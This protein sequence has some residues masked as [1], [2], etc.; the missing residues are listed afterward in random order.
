[1]LWE[2]EPEECPLNCRLFSEVRNVLMLWERG[3][4]EQCPWERDPE[5]FTF[6]GR[7]SLS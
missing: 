7:L 1:M 6:V 5:K 3:Y 2:R 4:P